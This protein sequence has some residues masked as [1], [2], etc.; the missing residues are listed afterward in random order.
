M[1]DFV[2]LRWRVGHPQRRCSAPP[3]GRAV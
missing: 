1:T 3:T 2:S